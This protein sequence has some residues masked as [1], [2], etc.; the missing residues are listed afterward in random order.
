M[1]KF[2]YV[3]QIIIFM[4]APITLI[5]AA[6]PMFEKILFVIFMVIIFS[7]STFFLGKL[8]HRVVFYIEVREKE[9]YLKCN[10]KR[11]LY[12]LKDIQIQYFN[13]LYGINEFF[14]IP[15]NPL[16]EKNKQS[17]FRNFVRRFWAI[18]AYINNTNKAIFEK[19]LSKYGCT[20]EKISI[21]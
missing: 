6:N 21:L 15:V 1:M 5:K 13:N 7:V 14:F 11:Y 16:Q 9:I 3:F 20:I 8:N 4:V 2:L 10:K 18:K 17:F 12:N 19:E